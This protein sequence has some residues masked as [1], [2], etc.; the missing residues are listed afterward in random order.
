MFGSLAFLAAYR[1][2]R[3]LIPGTVVVA[4][5]HIIRGWVWPQSV[6][7]VSS[8]SEWRWMEHAAWVVFENAFLILTIVQSR[9]DMVDIAGMRL[10]LEE[11]GPGVGEH[12]EQLQ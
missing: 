1:D 10:N 9:K 2:W 8:G 11:H 3:T 4:L 7:G 12:V 5:D 6:Y